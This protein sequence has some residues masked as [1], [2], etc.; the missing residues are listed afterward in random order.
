MPNNIITVHDEI[1]VC[2]PVDPCLPTGIRLKLELSGKIR[3]Y[4]RKRF[5]D[6]TELKTYNFKPAQ[7]VKNMT[8]KVTHGSG[9]DKNSWKLES[10]FPQFSATGNTFAEFV[11][12]IEEFE[13]IEVPFGP[14]LPPV[15]HADWWRFTSHRI[16]SGLGD[17]DLRIEWNAAPMYSYT[18]TV[19]TIPDLVSMRFTVGK[20][21]GK[22]K[23]K[24]KREPK[25]AKGYQPPV[26]FD[27]R[28]MNWS[29][30]GATRHGM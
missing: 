14:T 9:W 23:R 11:V 28:H 18:F 6:M 13:S 1:N 19:D 26:T 3:G 15:D 2:V 7:A 8:L 25:K 4:L 12:A 10:I 30:R 16:F 24:E 22:K 29:P 20:S 5:A 27:T 21:R 17:L